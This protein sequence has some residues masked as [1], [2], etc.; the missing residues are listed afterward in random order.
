MRSCGRC[1]SRVRLRCL[2]LSR[3]RSLRCIRAIRGNTTKVL[4]AFW[5]FLRGQSQPVLNAHERKIPPLSY[6]CL[7]SRRLRIHR[8]YARTTGISN[9]AAIPRE[10]A[11]MVRYRFRARG[12]RHAS[13]L[14][15]HSRS[16]GACCPSSLRT[17]TNASRRHPARASDEREQPAGRSVMSAAS[18]PWDKEQRLLLGEW[19]RR[20]PN[21]DQSA[22]NS[23]R[24]EHPDFEYHSAELLLTKRRQLLTLGIIDPKNDEDRAAIERGKKTKPKT[25]KAYHPAERHYRNVRSA[26]RRMRQ[27]VHY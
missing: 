2:I 10:R 1:L 9:P 7:S 19:F 21:G 15:R 25:Q 16:C 26:N 6:R 23:F 20:F 11:R 22:L 27:E 4:L 3:F 14:G 5:G 8:R 24:E 18:L 12:I 13:L 17:R